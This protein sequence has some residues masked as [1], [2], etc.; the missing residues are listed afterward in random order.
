MPVTPPSR[1]PLRAPIES[2]RISELDMLRVDL[3]DLPLVHHISMPPPSPWP[4]EAPAS[5]QP[6]ILPPPPRLP[7]QSVRLFGAGT[8]RVFG[9]IRLWLWK[10]RGLFGG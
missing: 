2:D 6:T 3:E 4:D 7:N 1:I 5:R 10:L 9:S 8:W